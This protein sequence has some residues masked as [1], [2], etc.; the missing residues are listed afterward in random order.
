MRPE[1]QVEAKHKAVLGGLANQRI[2][3]FDLVRK[4]LMIGDTAAALVHRLSVGL[5]NSCAVVVI[6]INQIDIAGHIELARAQLAHAHHP[7]QSTLTA[8][9]QWRAVKRIQ[10]LC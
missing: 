4:I 3:G 9:A 8:W 1:R 2:K 10:R 7:H 5:P 6:H